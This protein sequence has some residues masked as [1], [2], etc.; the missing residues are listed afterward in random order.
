MECVCVT[1][2]VANNDV[3]ADADDVVAVEDF[4]DGSHSSGCC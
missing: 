2:L 4:I 1:V 3:G